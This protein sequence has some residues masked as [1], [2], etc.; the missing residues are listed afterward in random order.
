MLCSC[1]TRAPGT[2]SVTAASGAAAT[3]ELRSRVETLLAQPESADPAAAW[4]A[5]GPSAL[6]PVTEAYQDPRRPV[7]ARTRAV[8]ALAWVANPGAGAALLE[9]LKDAAAAVGFRAAAMR[10]LAQRDGPSSVGQLKPLLIQD[11]PELRT[12]AAGAL[13]LAGGDEARKSL[14]ER[15]AEEENVGVREALQ[16]NLS[17]V[18]P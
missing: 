3:P 5:L 16:Q 14:E 2:A 8:S 17:K 6:G 18:Q 7:E 1:A 15:L 9:I 11:A 13:G 12:A 10:A 4:K